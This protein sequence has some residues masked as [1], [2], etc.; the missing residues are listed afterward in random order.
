MGQTHP[1][2]HPQGLSLTEVAMRCREESARP[3]ERRDPIFC[4]ELFRRAVAG[5]DPA[6]WDAIYA[7]YQ[8]LVRYWL[9]AVADV[10][11]LIQETFARFSRAVTAERLAAGDFPSLGSLLA[12]LRVTAINRRIDAARHTAR[13]QQAQK[14]WWEEAQ[15][16]ADAAELASGRQ[17]LADHIA[18]LVTDET[19]R[20]VLRLSYEN[21]LPPREIARL[22]PQRFENAEAVSRIKE[23]LKKRLANDPWLR[24]YLKA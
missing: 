14:A 1:P 18:A 8:S 6:A 23:R 15:Q 16:R 12:Y 13:E 7:Q 10:E 22:Y 21:C 20:L 17:A 24:R 2:L 9:G 19:E 11:D 3:T 5:H 4:L